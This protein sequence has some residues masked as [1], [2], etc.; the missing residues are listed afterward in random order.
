[1]KI[2]LTIWD[3]RALITA[4]RRIGTMKP[5]IIIIVIALTMVVP[6]TSQGFGL[7]RYVY[8]GI[9]NQ[10][11]LDRGP[12]PKIRPKPCRP[13]SPLGAPPPGKHADAHRIYIQA[14]G[15]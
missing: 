12:I 4:A 2:L 13:A 10:L 9:S 1:M 6:P 14:E 3:K 11:G 5:G 15:F 8:D 7:L